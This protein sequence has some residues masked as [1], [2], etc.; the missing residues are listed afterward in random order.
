MGKAAVTAQ[1]AAG[2]RHHDDCGV[3]T[4]GGRLPGPAVE[5][6]LRRRGALGRGLPDGEQRLRDHHDRQNR[7]QRPHG[8]LNQQ[9]RAGENEEH[10]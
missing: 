7:E 2:D 3:A 10:Q 5:D 8:K 6:R 4:V 9:L 1:P